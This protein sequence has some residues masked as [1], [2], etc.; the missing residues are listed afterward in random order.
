MLDKLRKNKSSIITDGML[1]QHKV[2]KIEQKLDNQF[3]SKVQKVKDDIRKL[4]HVEIPRLER[5]E[6]MLSLYLDWTPENRRKICKID[7]G[8]D[9]YQRNLDKVMLQNSQL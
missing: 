2:K 5:D 8:I 6:E 7:I 3:D 1:V 9:A 4:K